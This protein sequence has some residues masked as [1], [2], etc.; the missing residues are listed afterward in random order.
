VSLKWAQTYLQFNTNW[1]ILPIDI[2]KST[3]GDAYFYARG[4]CPQ[5]NFFNYKLN[6]FWPHD[7]FLKTHKFP[8]FSNYGEE[9]IWGGGVTR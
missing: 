6:Q 4:T 5:E 2:S 1:K 7:C 9:L 3:I 8:V